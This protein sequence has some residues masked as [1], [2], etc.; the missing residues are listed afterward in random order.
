MIKECLERSIYT[1]LGN[2]TGFVLLKKLE[3]TRGLSLEVASR[4]PDELMEALREIFG[5]GAYAIERLV[6]RCLRA[7]TGDDLG[8]LSEFV[9]K[10]G[11]QGRT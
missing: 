11:A 6:I 4:K 5:D 7:K 1:I 10:L 9:R 8:T 3:S 2:A